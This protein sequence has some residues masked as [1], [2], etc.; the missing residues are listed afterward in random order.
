M[1]SSQLDFWQA[2]LDGL[3][4]QGLSPRGL[5]RG[6]N[7][8]ILEPR[9]GKS[10]SAFSDPMQLEIWTPKKRA[11]RTPVRRAPSAFTLLPLPI[12]HTKEAK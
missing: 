11:R 3:P 5:T 9:G 12:M 10:T 8:V 7:V 4:W 1:N 6:H 2:D